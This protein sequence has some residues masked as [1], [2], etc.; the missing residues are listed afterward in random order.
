M[1]R[2]WKWGFRANVKLHTGD[3]DKLPEIADKLTFKEFVSTKLAR[4]NVD[5]KLQ[6]NPL[7]FNGTLQTL[8]YAMH[9]SKTEFQ[10]SYGRELFKYSDGGQ[11][12]LDWIIEP[13][14]PEEFARLYKETLP[15]DSPRLHPKTRFFTPQELASITA[16]GQELTK[17]LCVVM[18]GL[19]G[20]SHEPLIRNLGQYLRQREHDWDVV[21]VNN[22]GCC[23]TKITTAR[24]FNAFSTDDIRDVI[25]DL[26]ERFPNRPIYAVGFSF[27]A[28]L[29]ANYLGQFADDASR[30]VKAAVLIGC[31]WDLVKSAL[32]LDSSWSGRYLFNPNLTL[33]L[34][35]IVKAN[36][37]E[38]QAN[39]PEFTDDVIAQAR[40]VKKTYEWDNLITCHT[41]DYDNVWD[42]YEDGLPQRQIH[43]ISVPTL[44]INSTDD[45]AVA[46]N[47]PIQEVLANPNLA[48]I[49]TDLGGHLG[50][51][52]SSGEF[53]CVEVADDFFTEFHRATT[54]G[55][56]G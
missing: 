29:L 45:P 32:H 52:Q 7:L 28:L 19:G 40:N 43:N 47:L 5:R 48:M 1:S 6:L 56:S 39:V 12:S 11:C 38:I 14:T 54:E 13:E 46:N 36:R 31:P 4:V 15:A 37:K 10:V 22:R 30:L 41:A 33:F 24:I 20:G 16:K 9:N 49:E 26:S 18:H 8:Y 55:S 42:Y 17:P 50:W 3:E 35:K 23:R 2:F 27:G 51:V 34:N 21:V 25:V 53:W 44:I